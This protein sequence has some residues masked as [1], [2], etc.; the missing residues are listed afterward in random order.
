MPTSARRRATAADLALR[1]L[2]PRDLETLVRHRR[3]MW[4]DIGEGGAAALD[5]ADRAY[6]RWLRERFRSRRIVAFGLVTGEGITVSTGVLYLRPPDE[7][8]P[9]P[10]QRSG[11]YLMSM[12]TE[13]P[14][15]RQGL[16]ERI[17]RAC[18]DW[19]RREGKAVI[20]LRAAPMG[21]GLYRRLGFER[22]WEMR[23]ELHRPP[24]GSARATRRIVPIL[25]RA[26]KGR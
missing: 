17:V 21:R 16:A 25:P 14:W 15:R 23:L 19:S 13:P 20:T 11:P 10:G 12:Y 26:R 2:G 7:P 5:V 3:R 9:N 24:P 1:R 18:I 8:R 6:R 4:E 22:R